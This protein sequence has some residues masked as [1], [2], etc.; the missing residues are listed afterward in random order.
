MRTMAE[1][2]EQFFDDG[3]QDQLLYQPM[4]HPSFAGWRVHQP[5]VERWKMM[6]ST[7]LT[8]DNGTVIDLGCHT[9]W[10]CRQFSRFKWFAYGYDKNPV[11]IEAATTFLKQYDGYPSP[12]YTVGDLNATTLRKADVALCLSLVMYMFPKDAPACAGWRF[13]DRISNLASVMFLDFGGQ[14]AGHLPFTRETFGDS[15]LLNTSYTSCDLLGNT[16]L[17]NR[18]FYMLRR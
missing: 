15:A 7:G 18:P 4:E 1:W 5:C 13:L 9:G 10:F 14:Y 3:R 11:V 12:V 2:K 8:K 6:E 17:Q 16:G